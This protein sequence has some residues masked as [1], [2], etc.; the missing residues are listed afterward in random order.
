MTIYFPQVLSV[1]DDHRSLYM[2]I[3]Q[4]SQVVVYFHRW[5]LV[6]LASFKMTNSDFSGVTT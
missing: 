3:I 4:S 5:V 2:A 1:F 6:G